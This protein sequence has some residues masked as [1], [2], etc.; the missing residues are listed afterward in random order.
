MCG[1][2]KREKGAYCPTP[3]G[4][5]AGVWYKQKTLP[6]RER[7]LRQHEEPYSFGLRLQ[8]T[9]KDTFLL[10]FLVN[11]RLAL[12]FE[13]VFLQIILRNIFCQLQVFPA[14]LAMLPL[15]PLQPLSWVGWWYDSMPKLALSSHSGIFATS[16]R[17]FS[18]NLDL[19]SLKTHVRVTS[20]YVSTSLNK[21]INLN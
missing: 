16:K 19:T 20:L 15:P 17:D 9:G 2:H 7:F 4:S 6:C 18:Y 10:C 14:V 1:S 21:D 12:R 11:Q 8:R 13:D 5:L 3:G